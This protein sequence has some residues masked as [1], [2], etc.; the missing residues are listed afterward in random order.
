MERAYEGLL[1]ELLHD[2]ERATGAS[3]ELAGQTRCPR[4]DSNLRHLF[5]REVLYPL[6]YG[7]AAP[8]VANARATPTDTGRSAESP[9]I[10]GIADT[11]RGDPPVLASSRRG[12]LR[13]ER[14]RDG[15]QV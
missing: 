10:P 2:R 14:V 9:G 12:E 8:S 7:G 5:R 11:R 1:H 4:Q 6:S 3:D 15:G 13:L